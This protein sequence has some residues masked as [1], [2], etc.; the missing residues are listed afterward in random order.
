MPSN[1]EAKGLK[2]IPPSL[3]SCQLCIIMCISCVLL[4][5]IKNEKRN[6]NTDILP[7]DKRCRLILVRVYWLV[8]IC[9]TKS[10]IPKQTRFS[11][12]HSQLAR[13]TYIIEKVMGWTVRINAC[14]NRDGCSKMINVVCKLLYHQTLKSC[15]SKYLKI[16]YINENYI[17][18]HN[19]KFT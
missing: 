6:R 18:V 16:Y 2:L 1:L 12:N 4:Y 7:F 19:S 9:Y 13:C 3:D 15:C 10:I 8:W 5:F 11:I 17:N 14:P